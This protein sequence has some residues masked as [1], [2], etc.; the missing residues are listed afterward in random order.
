M[1]MGLI[2]A[3]RAYGIMGEVASI[4]AQDTAERPL[5]RECDRRG[6]P[7][8]RL[9]FSPAINVIAAGRL[10]KEFERDGIDLLHGH[11]YKPDVLFGML[12]AGIRCIPMLTTVHGWT[13]TRRFSKMSLY[14]L[15]DRISWR[16]MDRVVAVAESS[17]VHMGRRPRLNA[18]TIENGI[19]FPTDMSLSP[20]GLAV[21]ERIKQHC[22][23]RTCIGMVAR[24]SREKGIDTMLSAMC[25]LREE[26][27]Q[28]ALVIIGEGQLRGNIERLIEGYELGSSV[29]LTGYVEN[30]S[31]LMPCFD[32]LVMPSRTEGLPISLLEAMACK[33]PVIASRVGQIPQVM[34][35]GECGHLIDPEDDAALASG[36]KRI[37]DDS[38]YRIALVQNASKHVTAEYSI[39]QAARKYMLLYRELLE[40]KKTN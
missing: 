15:L 29:L 2:E 31:Q 19:M 14:Q 32:L 30:A 7:C 10:L 11:G 3:Q 21:A 28:C 24:L 17:P 25:R 5:E 23:G 6:I 26:G 39:Q 40:Q 35:G 12:L 4:A 13:E 37:V 20:A 27:S 36:I 18:K 9:R 33:V 16:W 22:G 34:K 1:L 8:R 38:Q